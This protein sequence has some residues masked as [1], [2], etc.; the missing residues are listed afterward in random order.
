M[1]I[2]AELERFFSEVVYP[3]RW[4]VLAGVL[5]AAAAAAA[6][7]YRRG[8]HR[9]L[10]RHRLATA[11][12]AVPLVAGAVP[13]G[14]YLLSPLIERSYVNEASPLAASA[15]GSGMTAAPTPSVE[16]ASMPA[17]PFAPRV[18]FEG[19]F[20]GADDFHF[21]RGKA[22]LIETAPGRYALR[23]EEF[24]VRNGP[25][26]F[27]YLSPDQGGG[28]EG[29]LNLGR[30]KATDGAFNYEVPPG[31]DVSRY[32][33]AIVWCRRFSVLFAAAPLMEA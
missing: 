27:V 32:R 10:W 8:W 13:L 16:P 15:E 20:Q 7:G 21:G 17:P 33:T 12:V 31:T 18:A 28:N 2:F 25:D 3:N 26:L 23:V 19:Q 4:P 5:L 24:S 11:L 14:S 29:A 9:T 30:L 1:N 22:L 6:I